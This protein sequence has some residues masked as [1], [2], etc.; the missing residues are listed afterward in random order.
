M[1]EAI[2]QQG[3][4]VD[5]F[6]EMRLFSIKGHMIEG[7]DGQLSLRRVIYHLHCT[8]LSPLSHYGYDVYD[9]H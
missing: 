3:C 9:I 2:S 7:L 5:L 1:R 8:K 6:S 4:I